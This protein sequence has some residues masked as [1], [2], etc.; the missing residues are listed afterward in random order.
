[1]TGWPCGRLRDSLRLEYGLDELI[2]EFFVGLVEANPG[3]AEDLEAAQAFEP[4]Q[5][6]PSLPDLVHQL[7][8]SSLYEV[9]SGSLIWTGRISRAIVGRLFSTG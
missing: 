2:E 5:S 9:S 7:Y 4:D 1:M 8:L 6:P 3:F